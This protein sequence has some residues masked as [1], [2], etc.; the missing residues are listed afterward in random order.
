MDRWQAN[1]RCHYAKTY[2][3]TP[4]HGHVASQR[5]YARKRNGVASER[6]SELF[7][8]S[9]TTAAAELRRAVRAAKQAHGQ[10][11]ADKL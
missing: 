11:T 4:S 3:I 8:S 1:E 9:V 2:S 6:A 7:S 5:S 10:S